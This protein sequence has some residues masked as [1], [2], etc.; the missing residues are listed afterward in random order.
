MQSAA[1]GG[2]PERCGACAAAA[3]N[4]IS[5]VEI[6]TIQFPAEVYNVDTLLRHSYYRRTV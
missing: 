5:S 6:F 2:G 1:I 3:A 4:I